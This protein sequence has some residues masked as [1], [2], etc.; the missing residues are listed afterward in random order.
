MFIHGVCADAVNLFLPRVEREA[1]SISSK[2]LVK[3]LSFSYSLLQL[4]NLTNL[5]NI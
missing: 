5:F 4:V 3:K 1:I 2:I